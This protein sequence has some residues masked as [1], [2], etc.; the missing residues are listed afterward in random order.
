MRSLITTAMTLALVLGP[1]ASVAAQ[2]GEAAQPSSGCD[3]PLAEPGDYEAVNDF[4][5]AN[6]KYFV[7][8]P[9]SYAEIVPAPL[10]LVLGSGGGSAH[11]NYGGRRDYFEDE[12]MLIVIAGAESGKQRAPATQLALIDQ[13]AADYCIDLRRVHVEGSS[14]SAY[15]AALLACE[16]SDRIAS[17]SDGAG[18]FVVSPC[19]PERPVPL[20]AFT[21]DPDRASVTRS[22]EEWVELNGCEPEPRVED[23]GSGIARKSYQGCEADVLFYDIAGLGH[24][25]VMHECVGPFAQ[26]YCAEYE[27]LDELDEAQRFFKEHPLSE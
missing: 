14:S 9:P 5:G 17:F 19:E 6:Q 8:V 18:S 4:D 22:V 7:I 13:V 21:G 26:A 10:H 1:A 12:P 15:A 25:A 2:T 3:A 23:L 20:L 11:M 27:E 16:G 24:K